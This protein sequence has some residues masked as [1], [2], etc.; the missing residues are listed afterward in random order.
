[1]EPKEAVGLLLGYFDESMCQ[2]NGCL[3]LIEEIATCLDRL[4]LAMDLAGAWILADV[5]DNDYDLATALRQYLLDYQ[6]NQKELLSDK[7]FTSASIYIHEDGL[8]GVGDQPVV[9]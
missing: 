2:G 5:E 6:R 1:M 9:A 3:R 7:G 4:A 8:D